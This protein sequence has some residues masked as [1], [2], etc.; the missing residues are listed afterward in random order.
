MFGRIKSYINELRQD[1]GLYPFIMDDI[2][3]RTA[4]IKGAYLLENEVFAHYPDDRTLTDWFELYIT[5]SATRSASIGE[6]LASGFISPET[7]V[8][9]WMDS[10]THYELMI[11]NKYSEVGVYVERN[12]N[13]S[14]MSVLHLGHVFD[15]L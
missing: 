8:D 2:L 7:I 11:S 5:Q 13:G 14:L 3:T 12:M 15:V 6:N 4:T 10:P 1:L 9:A